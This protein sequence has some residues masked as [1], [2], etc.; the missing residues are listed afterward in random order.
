MKKWKAFLLTVLAVL[1]LTAAEAV[2]QEKAGETVIYPNTAFTDHLASA[3]SLNRYSVTLPSAGMV[4]LSFTHGTVTE[5]SAWWEITMT[6]PS[7]TEVHYMTADTAAQEYV[8]CRQGL[9]AGTYYVKVGPGWSIY[10]NKFWSGADYQ[11]RVNFTA[12]EDWETEINN[13]KDTAD[14][15]T[16]G[17]TV[18]GTVRDRFPLTEKAREDFDYYKFTLAKPGWITVSFSHDPVTDSTAEGALWQLSLRTSEWVNLFHDKY[19]R[20]ET[21]EDVS[22][23]IGLPA[24]T[25]Y[26]FV[27]NNRQLYV[28]TWNY[29]A[30]EYR[31]RVDYTEDDSWEAEPND[32]I[33]T[34]QEIS[35]GVFIHGTLFYTGDYKY[36]DY[37][38]FTVPEETDLSV[39][40]TH[41]YVDSEESYWKLTIIGKNEKEYLQGV[42][43]GNERGEKETEKVRLAPGTYY[44]SMMLGDKLNDAP[45]AFRLN[46]PADIGKCT[47]SDIPDQVYTGKAITPA[48]TVMDGSKK[49]TEGT[50]YTVEYGNNKN[51]GEATV[52]ITGT[53]SYK[54]TNSAAFT[55]LPQKVSLSK[56][57]PGAKALTVKW[58][59][60]SGIDGYEIEYSLKKSFKSSKKITV[61]KAK[62][63]EY[64][65]TKLKSKKTYY[66]RIRAFK[67]VKGKTYYSEWSKVLS[68]KTK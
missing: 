33:D 14:V 28:T 60:G 55:I 36:K 24:G 50:D 30:A 61:K 3:D 53:G 18:H 2:A 56:L 20:N 5:D 62:T 32:T 4:T 9:P 52:T 48:I 67:K 64:E 45:Y 12:S 51:V 39:T 11:L 42:Y 22:P 49:L 16:T 44:V 41:D 54:G 21:G 43:K 65:I 8:S 35:T 26:I 29:S 15:I 57:V 13:T 63:T 47:V 25:Y 27:G 17:Q 34:A 58:K 19:Q 38:R 40:F 31:I 68:K 1:C 10:G 59:K 23:K 7:G 37:F 66:V 46:L 6:D